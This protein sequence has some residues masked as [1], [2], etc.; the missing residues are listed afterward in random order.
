VRFFGPTGIINTTTIDGLLEGQNCAG[1]PNTTAADKAVKEPDGG[2][3]DSVWHGLGV[4]V[5][6]RTKPR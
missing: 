4:V 1:C 5:A 6:K 2:D 3:N